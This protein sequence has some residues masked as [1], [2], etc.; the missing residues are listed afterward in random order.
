MKNK[1]EIRPK[2]YLAMIGKKYP[3]V[4]RLFD[5][6]RADRGKKLPDW[7]NWCFCPLAAAYAIVSGGGN[8]Q[9][10][11]DN[12]GDVSVLGG[13]A[14][15]RLSQ[16]IY[17]FDPVLYEYLIKTPIAGDIPVDVLLRL[18][19]WCVYIE[20]PG[21]SYVNT[22]MLGAFVFLEYD[23]NADRKEL[24]LLLDLDIDGESE[25]V[26]MP[27]HCEQGTISDAFMAMVEESKR[28]GLKGENS[29][30]V[31]QAIPGIIDSLS[32]VVS[33]V[34]YL[35]SQ[36]A[37]YVDGK[38]PARPRFKK[39]KKGLRYF[40]PDKYRVWDVG[41]RVGAALKLA[42]AKAESTNRTDGEERSRPRGHIRRA[43]W[44]GYWTGPKEKQKLILRW[45]PPLA[46]NIENYDIQPAVVHEVKS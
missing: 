3:D 34:L 42:L 32:A 6:F 40:P 46:I 29:R 26:G 41:V 10:T 18:P 38:K 8:N 20:T 11:P 28:H 45:I 30:M 35:C 37:D 43:H 23:T 24:R 2:K 17:R 19:E 33:L 39:T 12:V 4:W 21:L 27:L 13:L 15:W 5:Q 14:A 9:C 7:P 25:L 31:E 36:T 16:G 1:R 22:P 44:H